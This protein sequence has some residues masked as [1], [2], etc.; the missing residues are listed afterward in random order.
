[1]LK[2]IILTLAHR[3]L[4]ARPCVAQRRSRRRPRPARRSN[5]AVPEVRRFDLPNGLKVRFVPYGSVPKVAVRLVTQTGNIDESENEVWLA[6]L[7]ADDDGAGHDHTLLAADRARGGHDGRR[8]R[9]RRR[10]EPDHHRHRCLLRVGASTAVKLVADVARNPLL[11]RVRAGAHQGR[12]APQAVDRS[13]A[14]PGRWRQE[15][16]AQVLYRQ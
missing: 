10:A 5:F 6:D 3:A 4:R 7:T 11:P 14:S 9:H 15:K 8:A 1:M 16:F 13:A 2:T 12:P